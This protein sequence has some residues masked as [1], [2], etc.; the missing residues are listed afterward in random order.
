MIVMYKRSQKIEEKR[1][2]RFCKY[3]DVDYGSEWGTCQNDKVMDMI[4]VGYCDD[5]DFYFTFGCVLWEAK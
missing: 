3:W 5:W 2:C 4:N 1:L